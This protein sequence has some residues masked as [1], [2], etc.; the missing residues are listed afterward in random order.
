MKATLNAGDT[1]TISMGHVTSGLFSQQ[2]EDS[3]E[4]PVKRN[5]GLHSLTSKPDHTILGFAC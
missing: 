5:V 3:T 2:R 4:S 1:I